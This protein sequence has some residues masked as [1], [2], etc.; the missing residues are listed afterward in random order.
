[1]RLLADYADLAWQRAWNGDYGGAMTLNG[2]VYCTALKEDVEPVLAALDE[3][4]IGATLSG[5]GSAYV[6]LA[7]DTG[8]QRAIAIRWGEFEGNVITPEII[9]N[10]VV[11][12]P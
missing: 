7:T 12:Y 4:A 1:M 11:E 8:V 5:T 9:N 10:G 2:L 6:A 3:G